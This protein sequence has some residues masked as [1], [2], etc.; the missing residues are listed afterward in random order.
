MPSSP[1]SEAL[2]KGH[3]TQTTAKVELDA[4]CPLLPRVV[5]VLREVVKEEHVLK[6]YI[7]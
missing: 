5:N 6:R 1:Q 2:E 3:P 4:C 7:C